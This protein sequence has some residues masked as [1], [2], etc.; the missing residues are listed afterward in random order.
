VNPG[1]QDYHG[2]QLVSVN[3]ARA[4]QTT[5]TNKSGNSMYSNANS[6]S[7]ALHQQAVKHVMQNQQQ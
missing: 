4:Q 2:Q 1:S 7:Q 3:F 6:Q 5:A